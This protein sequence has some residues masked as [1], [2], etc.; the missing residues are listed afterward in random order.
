MT[1]LGASAT[2]GAGQAKAA[3]AAKNKDEATGW[4]GG[5][6]I[7]QAV[8]EAAG[9]EAVGVFQ[10][11]V[12]L[13]PDTSP[14][15]QAAQHPPAGQGSFGRPREEEQGC[16]CGCLQ[17]CASEGRLGGAEG[18][19]VQETSYLGAC[20]LT[21]RRKHSSGQRLGSAHRPGEREAGAAGL[22]EATVPPTP[23]LLEA[24]A[25]GQGGAPGL[26]WLQTALKSRE[27]WGD[28]LL[29]HLLTEPPHSKCLEMSGP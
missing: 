18:S 26:P 21:G 11:P 6:A 5:S 24:R 22:G 15:S 14:N 7:H 10:S 27:V 13:P 2:C 20:D 16:T 4:S 19:V 17:A 3:A 29:L 12:L 8:P 28:F 9:E 25:A 1:S 23:A